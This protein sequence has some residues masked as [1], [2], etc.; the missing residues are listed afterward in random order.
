MNPRRIDASASHLPVEATV[1]AY[2]TEFPGRVRGYY[3]LGSHAAS[4]SLPT[5]DLDLLVLFR[6]RLVD[7]ERARAEAIRAR[8]VASSPAE[9]DI[10]LAAEADLSAGLDP[11]FKLA[12]QLIAGDDVRDAYP[13]VPLDEW[14]RD[15]M[16]SSY[17]RIITL[18][19]RPLPVTLP[20]MYPD[21]GDAF[22]GYTRRPT[23]LPG[24]GEAPGTRDLIRSVG[25]AA[26]AL[27]AL[28]A[29][30]FVALKRDCHTLYR[31]HIGDEWSDLLEA[32]YVRCRAAWQYL[33]PGDAA[34]RAELRDLCGRT[35]G[36]ENAFMRIYRDYLLGELRG[37]GQVQRERA[38]WVLER[39]PWQDDE[40][41]ATMGSADHLP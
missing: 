5:S 20:L 39:I 36:F 2:E 26:T 28:R 27:L 3:L 29:G 9:L 37:A 19:A 12:S 32:L 40:I 22:Y 10:E 15:R 7:A 24:G 13:L 35:L 18:F 34:G 14:V 30:V 17:W 31:A 41:I 4:D 1:A 6:D 8:C 23:R 25:W 33:I 11:N 38:H 21:G 16:H